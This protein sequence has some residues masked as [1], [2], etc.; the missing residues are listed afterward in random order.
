MPA[1]PVVPNV[2]KLTLGWTIG[3]DSTAETVTHWQYS[4]GAPNSADCITLAALFLSGAAAHFPAEMPTNCRLASAT[5]LDLASSTGA[6]GTSTSGFVG[7][8]TG[9]QMSGGTCFVVNHQIARR[10]RGGKPKS[11]LPFGVA[12]DLSDPQHWSS[13]FTAAAGGAWGTVQGGFIG[14]AGGTTT[15]THQVNVSYYQG[16]NPPTTLPSGRV[17][18]SPKLRSSPVVDVVVASAGSTR[19]GSQRRRN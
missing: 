10:Y 7:T 3:G 4:G 19:P 15:I 13:T 16:V 1:L 8:R 17:K 5:V 2:L 9:A 14:S 18:Q 6:E 11:F 12:G